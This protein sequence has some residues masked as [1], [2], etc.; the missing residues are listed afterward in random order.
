MTSI[1]WL[2]ALVLFLQLP[3]PLFWF[4]V[5]PQVSFWRQ[6]QTAGYVTGVL[7]SWGPVTVCMVLFRHELFRSDWPAAWMIVAGLA[8]I[9]FEGWIFWR[10]K[11]DLGAARLVGK[12][13]LSGGGEVVRRGI[14]AHIRHPRY[15]GSFLAI[16]GA[17]F[18]AGTRLLWAV[19]TAWSL[20]TLIA[21]AL[22]ERELR[23]RFGGAY[24][25]Y[26][27]GVPRFLPLRWKPHER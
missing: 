18:L 23:T 6:H 3:I 14:Y 5:H 2:A 19:A 1:R 16:L 27:R 25:E 17:C 22:E 21:I 12:T 13:E 4:V 20:L 9:I 10:V 24:V 11:R 7:L 15:L 8:L 26:C